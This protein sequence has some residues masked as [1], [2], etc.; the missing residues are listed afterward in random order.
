MV[1]FSSTI[2]KMS[3]GLPMLNELTFPGVTSFST[4]P[5]SHKDLMANFKVTPEC[6]S[7][8]SAIVTDIISDGYYFEGAKVNRDAAQKFCDENFFDQVLE[9]FLFDVFV[10]GNGFIWKKM[11]SDDQLKE[12]VTG[13]MKKSGFEMK[14]DTFYRLYTKAKTDE[15]ATSVHSLRNVAATS[16]EINTTDIYGSR[17]IYTQ[18][19]GANESNFDEGEIIHMKDL[20]IDG[21]LWGFSRAKS[22][23]QEMQLLSELKDYQG[24]FFNNNG[25]PDGVFVLPNELPGSPNYNL[26]V[27]QLKDSKKVTKRHGVMVYT[28]EVTWTMF[29]RMKDMEFKNLADWITKVL[30]MVWQ[31]PPSRYG[32]TGQKG[33]ETSLSNQG[34]YRNIAHHQAKL[35]SIL[36]SQLFGPHFKTKIKFNRSYKEDEVREV[37]VEKIKVDMIQQLL[38]AGLMTPEA[39]CD[40]L[41]IPEEQRPKGDMLGKP[42]IES[43]KAGG[44]FNQLLPGTGFDAINKGED[45]KRVDQSKTPKNRSEFS[46][47]R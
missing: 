42:Q 29:D 5:A 46:N 11:V 31:V 9:G 45:K 25:L 44:S 17:I 1:N 39:A 16:M 10:E 24:A 22:I 32:G 30:A 26:I 3:S 14:E 27:N 8:V 19:V 41:R 2:N 20:N 7:F 38:L 35:E 47:I 23:L 18:R 36:N 13:F 15:V 43:S 34:Y 12:F 21:K 28:G 37:Q 40:K 33:E 4:Q 6:I